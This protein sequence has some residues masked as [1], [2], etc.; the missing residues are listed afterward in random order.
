MTTTGSVT[1]TSQDG[2]GT[3]LVALRGEHDISTTPLLEQ[4]MRNL[5]PSCTLAI[6]DLSDA[7]FIDCSVLNWLLRTRSELGGA[8]NQSLRVIWGAPGS[9]VERVFHLVWLRDELSFYRSR[10]Q[11]LDQLAAAAC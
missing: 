9:L 11:A 2:N 1:V 7:T 8:G 3:W 5:S 10:Q 4:Q 6:V